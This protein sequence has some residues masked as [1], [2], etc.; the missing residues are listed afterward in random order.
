MGRG[1]GEERA[2]CRCSMYCLIIASRGFRCQVGLFRTRSGM[3]AHHALHNAIT[4]PLEPRVVELVCVGVGIAGTCS[5]SPNLG[6]VLAMVGGDP[7]GVNS[8]VGGIVIQ[9]HF[10]LLS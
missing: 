1:E 8:G 4:L 7:V 9:I 5:F 3:Y 2:G 10:L 6:L